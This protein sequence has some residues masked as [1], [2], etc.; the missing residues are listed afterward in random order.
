MSDKWGDTPRWARGVAYVLG[1]IVALVALLVMAL[2]VLLLIKLVW[3]ISVGV[4]G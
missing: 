3:W 2:V 1:A 4:F